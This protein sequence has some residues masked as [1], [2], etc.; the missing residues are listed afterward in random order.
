MGLATIIDVKK[1]KSAQTI[2]AVEP[3][4]KLTIAT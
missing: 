2:V 4:L 3:C 1:K